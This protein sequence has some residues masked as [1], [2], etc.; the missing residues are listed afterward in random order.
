ME[1]CLYQV[2]KQSLFA[3]CL[4]LATSA[5]GFQSFEVATIKPNSANDNRA[6]IQ[7]QPG[8]RFVAS[9]MS[10]KQ[11]IAFAYDMRDFQ[12][13]G[14]PGWVSAERFDVNAKGEGAEAGPDVLRVMMRGLLADRFKLKAHE[15]SKEMSIY[16]LV[17]GK[18]G[19]KLVKSAGDRKSTRLNSSHSTLS[20]MPS[21]A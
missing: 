2:M 1:L 4:G 19:S 18:G 17:V 21:S 9:G 6:M 16:A 3:I 20:R 13:T 11:L 14:E 5:W 10:L 8:G 15:E 12:I 7:I